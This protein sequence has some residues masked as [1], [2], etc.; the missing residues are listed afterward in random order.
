[1]AR[2]TSTFKCDRLGMNR[3]LVQVE[4]SESL[5]FDGV[6]IRGGERDGRLVFLRD[7]LDGVVTHLRLVGVNRCGLDPFFG[8]ERGVGH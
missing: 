2:A 3:S 4:N 5:F 1:M 7:F 6:R 8:G